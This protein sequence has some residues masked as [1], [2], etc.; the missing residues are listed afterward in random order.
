MQARQDNII[1]IYNKYPIRKKQPIQNDTSMQRKKLTLDSVGDNAFYTT[2]T[3]NEINRMFFTKNY[4]NHTGN[5]ILSKDYKIDPTSPETYCGKLRATPRKNAFIDEKA[6]ISPKGKKKVLS[7]KS[8]SRNIE[9]LNA[10]Y[11]VGKAGVFF[12][13]KATKN[14]GS[15]VNLQRRIRNLEEYA[16][17]LKA[18]TKELEQDIGE[19]DNCRYLI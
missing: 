16:E 7:L 11:S 8:K 6:K 18:K 9:E 4:V 19:E 5:D 13:G 3:L 15:N 10:T 12:I 2:Y 14:E 1:Q 17:L